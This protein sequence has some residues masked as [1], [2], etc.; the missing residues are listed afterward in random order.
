MLSSLYETMAIEQ[1][2][3][4]Q[5]CENKDVRSVVCLSFFGLKKSVRM[6]KRKGEKKRRKEI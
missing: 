4:F 5:A 1:Q 6:E 2:T 3:L